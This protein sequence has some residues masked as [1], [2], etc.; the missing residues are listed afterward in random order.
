MFFFKFFF[1]IG[2]YKILSRVPCAKQFCWLSILYI[3]VCIR[4][5]QLP[6]LSLPLPSPFVTISLF[7]MSAHHFF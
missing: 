7:S 5:S 6:N 3:V 1:L 4:Y 2:Y